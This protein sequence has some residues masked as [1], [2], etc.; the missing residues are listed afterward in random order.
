MHRLPRFWIRKEF[1]EH[2]AKNIKT[3]D[4]AVYMALSFHVNKQRR[5]FVGYRR[6]A[7]LLDMNKD[8]VM[9]CVKRLIA[10]GLVRRLDKQKNGEPS[11]LELT[12]VLF[13]NLNPSDSF[14]PKEL[15]KE[16]LKEDKRFRK[17]NEPEA[18]GK[19]IEKSRNLSGLEKLR[20]T[21]ENL[22]QNQIKKLEKGISK[23]NE[24]NT[25]K[26]GETLT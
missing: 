20:Q 11:K 4:Q 17:N 23:G 12:T 18:I 26:K 13:D 22:R 21:A 1:M 7:D 2:H 10:Y 5:T 6:I 15:K 25:I 24:S 8:T 3:S 9:R 19:I 16:L 14:R